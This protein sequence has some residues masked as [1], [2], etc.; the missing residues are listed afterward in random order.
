M[1]SLAAGASFAIQ[2][3]AR[4]GATGTTLLRVGFASLLLIA[5]WRPWRVRWTGRQL[6]GV[7][8]FGLTLGGMNLTF[9]LSLRTIPLGV[10]I[11]IEL[12]GPLAVAVT[13][14]RRV[15]DFAWIAMA[16]AG[17]A[18]LLPLGGFARTLDP[19]GLGWALAAGAL[20]A[21]YIVVGQKVARGHPGPALGLGLLVGAL[22]ALPFGVAVAGANLLTP[23]MLGAGLALAVLSSAVPYS[24]EMYALRRLPPQT[25]GVLLSLEPVMGALS[26]WLFL[27]QRL[28]P[29]QWLAIGCV[30]I[31]S[32]GVA[33]GAAGRAPEP[34]VGPEPP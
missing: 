4:V 2:L 26:G 18:L 27:H 15:H 3:F 10:A 14:S 7:A 11:A 19:V 16:V 6:L 1:A 28:A 21:G 31:A 22:I 8:L 9:Y 12:L 33:A 25:F 29:I 32:C 17:I 13:F 23:A 5:F 34:V 30:V 24:L 20:W